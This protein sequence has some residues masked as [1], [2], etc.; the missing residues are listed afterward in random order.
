MTVMSN[1]ALVEAIERSRKEWYLY[2][3]EGQKKVFD[4]F[5][6]ASNQIV[7]QISKYTKAG[8]IPPTRL[9]VLVVKIE[10]ELANLRLNYLRY[11]TAA[12]KKSIDFGVG[13]TI[14]SLNGLV[15]P[16]FKINIGSSYISVDGKVKKYDPR[17]EAY[18]DSV[19]AALNINAMKSLV[20]TS[21]GTIPLSSR[22]WDITWAAEK[23]IRSKLHTSIL[24]GQSSYKTANLIKKYLGVPGKFTGLELKEYKP[25]AGVYK[26]AYKNALRLA[27][28]EM[29][30]AFN[31]GVIKYSM[32]KPWITGWIWHTA[33][34]N[35][36]DD[37]S[38]KEGVFFPKDDA[39]YVPLHPW[40]LCWLEIVT[41]SNVMANV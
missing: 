30:R 31:E 34:G 36:C 13:S 6:Q 40:C 33:S 18:S 32:E 17:V 37:C 38:D 14:S 28:T 1:K 21:Y 7:E 29:N 27:T 5:K 4:L 2:T 22:V 26:S 8:K 24:L 9:R 35:P 11:L 41:N 12:Q 23:A 39:P 19:W 20:L 16:N 15:G 25:G 3:K 10:T